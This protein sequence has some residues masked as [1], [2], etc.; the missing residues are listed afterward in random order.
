MVLEPTEIAAVM[1]QE[2]ILSKQKALEE[3]A[4]IIKLF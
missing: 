3:A 1:T 4:V 2:R